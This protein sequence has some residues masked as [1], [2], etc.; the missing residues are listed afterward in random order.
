MTILVSALKLDALFSL[1]IVMTT[2]AGDLIVETA[3]VSLK[4]LF[5][6]KATHCY[7]QSGLGNCPDKWDYE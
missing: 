3:F 7:L 2:I 5:A 6:V 4:T 1:R